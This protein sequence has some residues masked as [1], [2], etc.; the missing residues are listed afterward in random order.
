MTAGCGITDPQNRRLKLE[1]RPLSSELVWADAGFS[2]DRRFAMARAAQ[3]GCMTRRIVSINDLPIAE[4]E[5]K[6]SW[7]SGRRPA[8]YP[9]S[10]E[11]GL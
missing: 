8:G 7:S 4:S 10:S 2:A 1:F 6:F 5:R 11:L 3:L 9:G